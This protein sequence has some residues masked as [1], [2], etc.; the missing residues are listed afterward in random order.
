MKMSISEIE[1]S[2]NHSPLSVTVSCE[3]NGA[4][5]SRKIKFSEIAIDPKLGMALMMVKAINEMEV[6]VKKVGA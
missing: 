5:L 2:S 3:H 6:E 1:R 4:S